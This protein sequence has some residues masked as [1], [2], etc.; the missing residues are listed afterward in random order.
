MRFGSPS[1][2]HGKRVL[3]WRKSNFPPAQH[4]S[5]LQEPSD[6]IVGV[7]PADAPTKT[8]RPGR[9]FHQH[10]LLP[11]T[12]P[13]RKDHSRTSRPASLA[14]IA[15]DSRPPGAGR[16]WPRREWGWSIRRG[17][18]RPGANRGAQGAH[19]RCSRQSRGTSPA[20]RSEAEIGCPVVASPHCAGFTKWGEAGRLP[21]FL[22]RIRGR[23]PPW[24]KKT[25]G[26]SPISPARKR[27]SSL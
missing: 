26:L 19:C 23:R 5:P 7:E 9:K 25:E 1:A 4:M 13:D 21:V 14:A 12:D 6:E 2:T 10:R 11:S 20:F 15:D 8:W 22:A 24:G 17:A 27:P 16:A 18:T 3:G